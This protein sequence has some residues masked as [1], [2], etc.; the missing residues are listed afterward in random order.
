MINYMLNG[1]VAIVLL[2]LRLIKKNIIQMS[3]YFP[4]PKSLKRWVKVELDLSSYVI[5]SD[6]KNTTGA[7]TSKLAQ[8]VNLPNLKS[9]VDKLDIINWYLFLFM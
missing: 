7:D 1:K 8:K 2:T 4:E 5:K 6:L 9:N 3:E